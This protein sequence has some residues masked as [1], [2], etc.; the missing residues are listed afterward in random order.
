MTSKPKF[1][2]K[3]LQKLFHDSNT[4]RTVEAIQNLDLDV[5]EREFV[6]LI[7]P[8]GC[9]KSTFLYICAGFEKPTSGTILF[10]GTPVKGPSPK[11]GIVFQDFVLYPWRTVRR[12]ITMGLE[13]KG[14]PKQ[15]AAKQTQ[16]WIDLV[17]LSGFEDAYPRQL[18]GGMKQRVAIARTLACEPEAVLMDEPFGALDV[19]TRNFMVSDLQ[20]VWEEAQKTIIFVT[21]SVEEAVT[22]AD[23]I[24]VFGARPSRIKE[25]IR[26]DIPRPR[27]DDDPAVVELRSRLVDLLRHETARSTQE[28]VADAKASDGLGAD[29]S[30]GRVP[31]EAA[32]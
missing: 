10:D 27:R 5:A 21:H 30:P 4:G 12:N 6:V 26:V 16:H 2:A 29:A 13:L 24:V 19:Q 22:L 23:R 31:Q 18:S 14:T 3:G 32:G 15:D 8:S 11:R 17:G 1:S 20:R 25:D 9:G 28:D 7:G